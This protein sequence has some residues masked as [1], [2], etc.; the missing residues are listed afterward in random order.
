MRPIVY[1]GSVLRLPALGWAALVLGFLA[2]AYGAAALAAAL[3]AGEPARPASAVYEELLRHRA[4]RADLAPLPEVPSVLERAAPRPS[5]TPVTSP[6]PP[7]RLR[8]PSI[9]VDAPVVRLGILP[10]GVMD[11]PAT[12]TD[13][14]WYDFT[15]KPGAGGNAVLSGHVDFYGYGPAVFW[16]LRELQRGD[17]IE[18][19]LLDGL[20]IEYEVTATTLTPVEELRMDAILAPTARETVTLITCGGTFA[21]GSYSHRLVVR[22]VRVAPH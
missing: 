10:S 12:P 7:V 20:R 8:I 22:A 15:G 4:G 19:E 1:A 5:P 9:G 13:V 14:G 11:S 16:R 6:A 21:D 17:R 3:A 18:V 2:L